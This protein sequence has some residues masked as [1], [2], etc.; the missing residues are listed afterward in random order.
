M[1]GDEAAYVSSFGLFYAGIKICNV[2][3]ASKK[4][5]TPHI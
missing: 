4:A 5:K 1:I 2:T 3:N